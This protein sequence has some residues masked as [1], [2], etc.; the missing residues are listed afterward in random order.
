ML[1]ADTRPEEE[2]DAEEILEEKEELEMQLFRMQA[3][4]KDIAKNGRGEVLG[5]DQTSEDKWVI[6]HAI[7]DGNACKIMIN[8]CETA[9][10]G[11]WDFSIQA[12]YKTD[13]TI[14]IGDIKGPSNKGYGSICMNYLKQKARQNNIPY[15]VGD[16]AERDWDHVDRLVHFYK[17]HQFNVDLDSENKCG[18]ILWING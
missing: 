14:K 7:D 16:I 2:K 5:I 12:T 4:I 6:V 10:K 3:N 17:K 9:Y 13:D 18:E 8:D 1:L 15:I 11:M